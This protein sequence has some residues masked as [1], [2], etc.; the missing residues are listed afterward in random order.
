MERLDADTLLE[1]ARDHFRAHAASYDL[2]PATLRI[3]YVLNWGG[4]VNHSYHVRDARRRYHLKLAT[5]PEYLE[6]LRQWFEL[7]PLLVPYRAPRIVSWIDLGAAAGLLFD[8]APGGRPALTED[9]LSEL[10]PVLQVLHAD[11]ALGAALREGRAAPTARD[12][13]AATL[14]E[15]LT[16]D[17]RG[18]RAEPPPFISRALLQELDDEVGALARAIEASAAF[19]EPMHGAVHG[20]L[21]LNNILWD[22]KGQWH[23]L[24]WDDACIGDPALDLATLLGPTAEDLTPLKH[25]DRASAVL[26]P[27]ARARLP[28]LGRATLLDWVIDPVSDWIDAR[29][30][31]S[32]ADAVRPEKERI[33]RAALALYRMHYR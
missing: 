12:V 22:G 18:I 33:H 16:E 19:D 9:L 20:D 10:L 1:K 7:A 13:Y 26:S 8:F 25:V 14:E 6:G 32:L 29:E 3:E 4:F 15:R 27:G 5:L 24:D 28:L 2:D 31:P 30:A 21:W 17:L 11:P 23:L